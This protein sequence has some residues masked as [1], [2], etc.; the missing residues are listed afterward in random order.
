[1]NIVKICLKYYSN[2][3]I[4]IKDILFNNISKDFNNL[5]VKNYIILGKYYAKKLRKGYAKR[6]RA[7]TNDS[8][9]KT[10]VE[11]VLSLLEIHYYEVNNINMVVD[12]FIINISTK[13]CSCKRWMLTCISCFHVISCMKF[14]KLP[15]KDYMLNETYEVIYQPLIHLANEEH[16][17]IRT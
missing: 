3:I 12:T 4:Y 2:N 15:P 16:L 11:L 5:S 6:L 13:E 1:Y 10:F 17:W 8:Q 14:M 9:S 7:L